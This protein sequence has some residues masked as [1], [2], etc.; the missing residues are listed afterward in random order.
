MGAAA[1]LPGTVNVNGGAVGV[2]F[3]TFGAGTGG[4]DGGAGL[5]AALPN[6]GA[7]G[8]VV[9]TNVADPSTIVP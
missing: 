4:G 5:N 9:P 7:L 3:G 6:P 1:P 2:S 8:Q